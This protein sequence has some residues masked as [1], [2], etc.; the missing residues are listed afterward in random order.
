MQNNLSPGFISVE[1]AV[2]L[3]AS[4]TRSNPVV[5]VNF[6]LNN[7]PFL[8]VNGNFNI[9]LLRRNEKGAVV[10]NGSKF[11]QIAN[12][13]ELAQLK[14]AIVE[15]KKEL[16]GKDIDPETIGVR[17]MTTAIDE[18]TNPQGRLSVNDKPMTKFGDPTTTG[19]RNI[20]KDGEY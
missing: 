16:T 18:E 7:I 4:D 3:I 19:E 15:K 8:R 5:D 10:E 6:M 14:H 1:E 20:T 17:A 13:W 9:K 11:V 12:E 2:K